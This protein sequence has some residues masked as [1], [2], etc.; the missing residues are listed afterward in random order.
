MLGISNVRGL[1]PPRYECDGQQTRPVASGD[2]IRER[3]A[4]TEVNQ[5]LEGNIVFFFS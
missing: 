3:I 4:G 2:V 1:D 5:L